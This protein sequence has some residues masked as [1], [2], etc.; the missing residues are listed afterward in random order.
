MVFAS[1]IAKVVGLS[2]NDL[3]AV[4]DV[5]A[6]L[7][8]VEAT[9][10]G[11]KDKVRMV[12]V[13]RRV[14]LY[15]LDAEALAIGTIRSDVG[16]FG[17][18]EEYDLCGTSADGLL[19]GIG[20]NGAGLGSN[21]R[22]HF[23]YAIGSEAARHIDK[24]TIHIIL[25]G[26]PI[27]VART[28][29]IRSG[30]IVPVIAT[31]AEIFGGDVAIAE[32]LAS[33]ERPV[34]PVLCTLGVVVELEVALGTCLERVGS[35]EGLPPTVAEVLGTALGEV[36]R[37]GFTIDGD[38]EVLGIDVAVLAD[39]GC[40]SGLAVADNLAF[41][42]EDVGIARCPFNSS[43][44]LSCWK[45]DVGVDFGAEAY[46]VEG[47]LD[48]SLCIGFAAPNLEAARLVGCRNVTIA[49][50]KGGEAESR[51]VGE[52]DGLTSQYALEFN[53]VI[54]VRMPLSEMLM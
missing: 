25:E 5:N 45:R 18:E 37:G 52:V 31:Y 4:H 6:L 22:F 44:K 2:D 50:T 38:S 16:G 49:R 15:F 3:L 10:I 14:N 33:V 43:A 36:G 46:L 26:V 9:A 21:G 39:G 42:G 23:E 34:L 51:D 53:Q 20:I 48:G 12:R 27:V 17:D 32:G 7:E 40:Q 1:A 13:V 41:V 35:R 11:S 29:G 28:A 19:V 8:A 54:A 24:R 47:V 30:G